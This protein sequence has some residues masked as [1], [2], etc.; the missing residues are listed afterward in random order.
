VR[1]RLLWFVVLPAAGGLAFLVAALLLLRPP[2]V[3]AVVESGLSK[4]LHLDAS[5]DALAITWLPRPRISGRGL[6]LR[7]PGRPELPPFIHIDAFAVD[8]GLL[9]MMRKHVEVVHADGLRIA[10][11]PGDSRDDLPQASGDESH[12]EIIVDHFVT[13]DAELRFVPRHADDTPLVFAIHALEVDDIGFGRSMPYRARLTNPVPEGL[14]TATG[15][16]G[17]WRSDNGVLTPLAGSYTFEN[18]NLAT[19]NGIGGTLSS[20]GQFQ[21]RLTAILVNGSAS[22]PDFSLDL[23][24]KPAP[25]TA[26]F[27]T[28]VDG[29]DG[30]TYLKRV[31]ATMAHTPMSVTGAITNLAGPGRHQVELDVHID[32]GRIEDLLALAIDSPKPIMVGDVTLDTKLSLPPGEARVRSRIRLSGTFGLGR[33]RFTDGTVQQKLQE[34]S[35]R[36]QGKKKDETPP[37]ERVLANLRGRFAIADGRVSLANLLFQVPGAVVALS[38]T[39][40]LATETMDFHGRLEMETSVSKAVGGFKSIFIKP[41]DRLF[42]KNGAGAVLPIR[43]SGSRTAPKFGL[44]MGKIFGRGDP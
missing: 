14:V 8:V 33:T 40:S 29:T 18:A 37:D 32:R 9:S 11:P 43:I 1:R 17:P 19:I 15:T 24:G 36:S 2:H 3:K 23:G 27:E 20:A 38:G 22:V 12:S 5:L 28:L 25:L 6:S 31:D 26:T 42:R 21:G 4:H 7:I 44:E 16:V 39:Y 30:T 10:V 35:R 41:F 34:L 13:H